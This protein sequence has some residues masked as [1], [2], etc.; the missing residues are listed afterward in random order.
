MTD[1]IIRNYPR[2]REGRSHTEAAHLLRLI[3]GPLL[4]RNQWNKTLTSC[5]REYEHELLVQERM[6]DEYLAWQDPQELGY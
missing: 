2:Y 3:Y 1:L 4:T 6:F 5:R